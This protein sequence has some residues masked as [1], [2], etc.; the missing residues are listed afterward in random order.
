MESAEGGLVGEPS[1]IEPLDSHVTTGA[2]LRHA[3][4]KGGI[5]SGTIRVSLALLIAAASIS[6]AVVAG[7]TAQGATADQLMAAGWH[8]VS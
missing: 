1:A 2:N 3:T 6:L 4:L 5:M 8:C 7:A